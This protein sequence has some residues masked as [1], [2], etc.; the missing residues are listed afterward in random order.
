M[1]R[2]LAPER[3]S[4]PI[5]SATT[6]DSDIFIL[7]VDDVLAG[8]ALR[9]NLTNSPNAVDEDPDWS[10]IED[11]IVDTNHSVSSNQQIPLTR[12]ST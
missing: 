8:I 4:E 6:I 12:R 7:N 11:V 3:Q 2:H 5:R 9:L 1:R 10:P